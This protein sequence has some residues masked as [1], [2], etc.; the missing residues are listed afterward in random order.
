MSWHV[1]KI[2]DRETMSMASRFNIHKLKL[3]FWL[4][5]ERETFYRI[6]SS[7][8]CWWKEKIISES[9]ALRLVHLFIFMPGRLKKQTT[10]TNTEKLSKVFGNISVTPLAVLNI[11]CCCCTCFIEVLFI[12][13]MK[14][15]K[16]F[17]H[18]VRFAPVFTHC[19]FL[20]KITST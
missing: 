19:S 10:W 4:Q 1:L 14:C 8:D 16:W 7:R 20:Q 2:W 5:M 12:F 17:K 18:G 13:W 6:S 9:L 15:W 3:I 11:K